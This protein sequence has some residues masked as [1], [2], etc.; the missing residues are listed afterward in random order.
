MAWA[1]SC[2]ASAKSPRTVPSSP[3]YLPPPPPPRRRRRL[4]NPR[5]PSAR[6]AQRRRGFDAVARAAASM[7]AFAGQA[8][9][10]PACG[11]HGNTPTAGGGRT[12]RATG[13]GPAGPRVPSALRRR[14]PIRA[15]RGSL[16]LSLSLTL[17][18][19]LSLSLS[20]LGSLFLSLFLSP[21]RP[22]LSPPESES[23]SDSVSSPRLS[24]RVSNQILSGL[25]RVAS[26]GWPRLSET[27]SSPT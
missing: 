4:L 5:P 16:S 11:R 24:P 14:G 20:R 17:S 23:L 19:S 10:T 9:R 7:F 2:S 25:R 13:R 15:V 18:L 12:G 6:L 8:S 3:A 27:R 22:S 21:Q 1:M 26:T